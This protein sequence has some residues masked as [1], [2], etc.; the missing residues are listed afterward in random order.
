M[1]GGAGTRLWPISKKSSPKHLHALA[2]GK[3]LI[4]ETVNRNLPLSGKERMLIISNSKQVPKIKKQ[5]PHLKNI[6]GEPTMRDTSGAIGLALAYINRI[7]PEAIVGFIPADH[8]IAKPKEYQ[9]AI[10]LAQETVKKFPNATVQ[11]GF[12]PTEPNTGLGY[13]RK[14]EKI[15]N[16]DGVYKIKEFIEKPP[17]EK[18]KK[19]LETGNYYWNG[20]MFIWKVSTALTLYKKHLPQTYKI[21]LKIGDSI[22]SEDENAVIKREFPKIKKISIDYAIIEKLKNQLFI[23][24]DCRWTDIGNWRTLYDILKLRYGTNVVVDS[25]HIGID[26][27]DVIIMAKDKLVAT[28]GIKNL[29]IISS[30]DAILVANKN[31]AQEVKEIVKRI[32]KNKDDKYL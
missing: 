1:A 9:K 14:G 11:I 8:Y 21:L 2:G 19:F 26:T 22:G 27:S 24:C 10:R 13:I 5:L 7:N 17:L 3:T 23:P 30:D 32:E 31:R 18:V 16:L 28:I 25:K 6:I 15:K 20:G 29:V 4:Q 12:E